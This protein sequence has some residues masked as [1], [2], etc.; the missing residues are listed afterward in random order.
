LNSNTLP[1]LKPLVDASIASREQGRS[2]H[3]LLI[4]GAVGSGK[5]AAAAWLAARHLQLADD[6]SLPQIPVSIPE[7]ADL[8]WIRP[9]EDKHTVGID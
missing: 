3:A 9:L 7:H 4:S 8:R 2:A 6:E 5:R 1:W